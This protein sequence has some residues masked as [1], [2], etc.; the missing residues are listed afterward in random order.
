MRRPVPGMIAALLLVLLVA[1]GVAQAGR[2][3]LKKAFIEKYKNRAT[4]ELQFAIDHAH[5]KPNAVKDNG[6]DGDLHMSGRALKAGLPM[7]AEIVN[8]AKAPQKNALALVKA[9][10]GNDAEVTLKGVWRLWFEHPSSEL[11]KQFDPVPKP[12]D[13]NPK[14]VFEV[15]PITGID[16]N[17]ILTSFVPIEGFRAYNAQTAFPYY[18]NLSLTVQS[19]DSGVKLVSPQSRYNYAEFWIELTQKP[20]KRQDGYTVMAIVKDAEGTPRTPGPRRMVFVE[21]TKSAEKVKTLK[22]GDEMHVLGI[23]RINLF[24]IAE[25]AKTAGA[26]GKKTNLPYE[27]IIVAQ[28]PDE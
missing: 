5:K 8:A 6:D 13:T 26:H 2:V 21:G 15:H 11:Q 28:L 23:P 4:I 9:N 18:E 24:E 1:P 20:V 14:H 12:K 3:L 10:E 25:I 7:V 17:E 27:M 16:T 19:D 22:K